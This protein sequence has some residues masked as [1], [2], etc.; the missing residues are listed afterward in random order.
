MSLKEYRVGDYEIKVA[1]GPLARTAGT[2]L[3]AAGAASAA[4]CAFTGTAARQVWAVT[5]VLV[6][7]AEYV[8]WRLLLARR[9]TGSPGD[10]VMVEIRRAG[11]DGQ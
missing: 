6:V 8:F 11:T 1:P 9:G 2:V 3:L 7:A 5:A 10:V 4:S